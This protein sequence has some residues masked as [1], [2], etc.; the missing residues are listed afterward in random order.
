MN[1]KTE[2]HKNERVV[3]NSIFGTIK[4]LIMPWKGLV[5]AFTASVN[6]VKKKLA[7]SA[8]WPGR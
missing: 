2:E 3:A 5:R 8:Y 4:L 7:K 1:Y 6:T